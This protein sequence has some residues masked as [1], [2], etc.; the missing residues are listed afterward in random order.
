MPTESSAQ[1]NNKS[2]TISMTSGIRYAALLI[3]LATNTILNPV[4]K[5][6]IPATRKS[7]I[8]QF[9]SLV[10]CIAIRGIN[11][12]NIVIPKMRYIIFTGITFRFLC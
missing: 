8:D 4:P 6:K 9:T 1:T 12:S 3:F 2:R 5:S 11:S 10:N 7:A